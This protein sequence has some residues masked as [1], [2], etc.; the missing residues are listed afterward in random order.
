MNPFEDRIGIT[1]EERVTNAINL[2]SDISVRNIGLLVERERGVENKPILTTELKEDKR[3]FGGHNTN[4]YSSYVVENLFN[5]TGGYSANV[6]QV[7]I[8]GDGSVAA[9]TTIKNA[10]QNTQTF[11]NTVIQNASV[12]QGQKNRVVI[13]NVEIGDE[14]TL[15]VDSTDGVT[16]VTHTFTYE[17]LTTDPLD[18]LNAIKDDFDT[19]F[20]TL[21]TVFTTAIVTGVLEI[22]SP[23]NITMAVTSSTLNNAFSEDILE[24][25]A[26]RE[27]EEDKGTWGNNLRVRVFPIGHVNGSADGYLLNVIYQGYLVETFTS[28]GAN[29]QSLIDQVN[30]RSEYI[31][32]NAIDLTKELTVAP[33]DGALSGGVYVAPAPADFEPKHN[34]I[35]GDPEGMAIFEGVDVQIL[36]CPEIFTANYAKL[37]DD[38][39][40]NLVVPKFFI[41]NMPYLA[42]ESVLT[43]YFN[44]LFSPD[45]SFV[46]G[47]LN[48]CQVPADANGNKIWIPNIGYVLGAGYIRKAG[49]FN[50]AVW[51]PPAGLETNAKGI[52]KFTHDTLSDV[53]LSRY[54]KRWRCNVV[55]YVKNTGYVV[56]SSRTYSNNSLFESIHVR[57]ETNWVIANLLVRNEKYLQRIYTPTLVKTMK[58]DNSIW[59]KNVYEQGGIEQSIPFSD[60]VVIDITTNR[61]NRKEVEMDYSWIPPECVEHIHIRVNRNDGILI[62]NFQN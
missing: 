14:F 48:W 5:N 50:G 54:V 4:M 9:S 44:T 31:L 20:G 61:T 11:V 7:R 51:T 16:P 53:T 40:R 28:V 17:A 35:T 33:F 49:L 8:I 30:Q 57:L 22:T 55:K 25:V 29:W 3:I 58:T 59:S 24:A 62:L 36:A 34:S 41:F 23:N 60:A 56:Y 26:G 21:G 13:G 52:F 2:G 18:V 37:C 45:Q 39:C 27:G 32:L 46:G 19:F 42:T 15:Q 47:Y 38:F 1:A 6:T 10:Y 43:A 12:S